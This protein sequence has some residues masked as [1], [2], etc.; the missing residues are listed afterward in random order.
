[1]RI[2]EAAPHQFI[3][4]GDHQYIDC[5]IFKNAGSD[6]VLRACYY[7]YENTDLVY[8]VSSDKSIEMSN[9]IS[10]ELKTILYLK[11]DRITISPQSELNEWRDRITKC[12]V[13][14]DAV[15]VDK[16]WIEYES[17]PKR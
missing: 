8:M 4:Y 10:D 9:S 3:F 2:Y 13:T 1:M 15:L 17:I 5:Y 11:Y 16:P 14:H 12:V 7:C 6:K